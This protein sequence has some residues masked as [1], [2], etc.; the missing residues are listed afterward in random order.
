MF[1]K[2]ISWFAMEK[3]NLPQQKHIFTSQKKCTTTENRGLFQKFPAS[4]G[5]FGYNLNSLQQVK[6]NL[7]IYLLMQMTSFSR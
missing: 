1:P 4:L 3:Q 2:P 7:F 5:N 6:D